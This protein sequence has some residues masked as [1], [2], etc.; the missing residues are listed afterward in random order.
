MECNAL[1]ERPPAQ[2]LVV[3]QPVKSGDFCPIPWCWEPCRKPCKECCNHIEN[4]HSENACHGCKT[5]CEECNMF[6][7]NWSL[8]WYREHGSKHSI[9]PR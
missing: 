6:V 3:P 8:E 2:L 7:D 1:V 5:V 4:Y 9:P